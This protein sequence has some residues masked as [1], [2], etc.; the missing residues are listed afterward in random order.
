MQLFLLSLSIN[1]SV[2]LLNQYNK[3]EVKIEK[4]KK[5]KKRKRGK[6]R[7]EYVLQVAY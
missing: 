7:I 2:E 4:K 5:K 3:K 1:T 6:A